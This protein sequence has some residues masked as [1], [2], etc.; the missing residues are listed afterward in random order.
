M[1]KVLITLINP[2][3]WIKA[4][5]FNK[6]K[7]KL[8]KSEYDLELNLYSRILKNDMMHYGYFDD[9][10]IDPET[11]ALKDFE[12]AQIKY[13]ENII[14]LIDNKSAAILDVGCGMGGLAA[15]LKEKNFTVETLTPNANQK[16]HMDAKYPAIPCH[17]SKF[18]NFNTDKKFGTIINA[19]SLQYISLADAFDS[20]GR[21]LLEGGKWIIA[22]YFKTHDGGVKKSGHVYDDFIAETKEKGWEI[23]WQRDITLNV[24]PTLNFL[25]MYVERFLLPLQH[26]AF[27]KLRSKY[28]GIYYLA[29]GLRGSIDAKIDKEIDTVRPDKFLKEKKYLMIVLGRQH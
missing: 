29:E 28:G 26:F 7:S 3:S 10:E 19:E 22:D 14:G 11:I 1:K 15:L 18:E 6:H 24:L 13:S 9:V 8:N 5:R 21:L 25:N 23:V 12:D 20:A 16:R 4:Y 27:E 2:I 17:K